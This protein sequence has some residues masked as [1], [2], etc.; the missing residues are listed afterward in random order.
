MRRQVHPQYRGCLVLTNQTKTNKT[1]RGE[2][3]E[4]PPARQLGQQPT[5]RPLPRDSDAPATPPCPRRRSRCC[6]ASSRCRSTT[7]CWG[8]T[9][10]RE[11]SRGTQVG[12]RVRCAPWLGS[13]IVPQCSGG[14]AGLPARAQQRAVLGQAPPSHLS[15]RPPHPPPH[16]RTP[17]EDPTVPDDSR[18]PTFA[19]VTL[20]IDNDR[21]V[22]VGGGGGAAWAPWVPSCR[23]G[24]PYSHAMPGAP[25]SVVLRP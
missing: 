15:A 2:A 19:A 22:A 8:S 6:A 10:R 4:H 9:V 20:Y 14:A 18:T 13:P 11:A 7:W 21:R 16:P 5:F 12:G 23:H 25:T 1:C 24:V 3:A 17:T